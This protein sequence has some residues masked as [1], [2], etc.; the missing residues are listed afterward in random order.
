MKSQLIL[1]NFYSIM[2]SARK[3]E[4][5]GG[6]AC[7]QQ[8]AKATTALGSLP[9]SRHDRRRTTFGDAVAVGSGRCVFADFLR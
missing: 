5:V 1:S 3:E 9:K 4:A 8:A 7:V 2:S 6:F